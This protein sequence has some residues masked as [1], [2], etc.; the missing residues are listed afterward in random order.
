M[1]P[2]QINAQSTLDDIAQ[3][4][5]RT[6]Q[7]AIYG[8]SSAIAILWGVLVAMGYSVNQFYPAAAGPIWL[9]VWSIGLIG[10]GLLSIT[11][12]Q[13]PESR[14][15]AGQVVLTQLALILFGSLF[16]WILQPANPRQLAAFWPLMFMMGYV[17]AGLWFG[18]FFLLCGLFVSAL[19]VF[20][21]LYSGP[22]LLIWMALC[23]GGALIAAGLYLRKIGLQA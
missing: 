19:T 15:M 18:R 23:N 7:A 10:T 3:V 9:C 17:I 5:A 6:Q 13:A 4:E 14:R 12:K 21:Y 1:S 22:W 2:D 16:I 8:A 11:L 20:G